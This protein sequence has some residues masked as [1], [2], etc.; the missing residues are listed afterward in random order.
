MK[1]AKIRLL[2]GA[3]AAQSRLRQPLRPIPNCRQGGD[4]DGRRRADVPVQEH[5]RERRQLEGSHD[6][7]RRREGRRPGRH[8]VRARARSRCSRR[9]T[10][11]SR[12]LPAGTVDTLL[13][14]ENKATLTKVLTYHVVPG[15]LLRKRPDGGDEGGGGK[16]MLKTVEGE[17]LTVDVKD[18]TIW[19]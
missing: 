8:A 15:R 9:P 1:F 7:G 4:G 13:K 5:R 3:A 17:E 14:P 2:A 18:G 11:R 10:T 12:K 19:V 6:A 16:A